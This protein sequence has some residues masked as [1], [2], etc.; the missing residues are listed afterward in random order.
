MDERWE[1]VE[2]LYHAARELDSHQQARFLD[3]ACRS[4]AQMRQQVDD[5]LRHDRQTTSFLNTPAA[6]QELLHKMK[7]LVESMAADDFH[8]TERF[9]VLRRLGAGG[10][11]VVYE[12]QDPEVRISTTR[13]GG[14]RVTPIGEAPS[15]YQTVQC[16]GD[17]GGTR[18]HTR[19]RSDDGTFSW[20]R[21]RPR[22]CDPRNTSL[23]VARRRLWDACFPGW[24][25]VQ[26]GSH[27]IRGADGANSFPRFGDRR[28]PP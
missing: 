27:A 23:R 6:D 12:V 21:R 2:S 10:M 3:E 18:R 4:D 16:A 14:L 5:L 11:G 9:T 26:R 20:K 8:G 17:A 28:T 22:A 15:R 25:L 24:R 1:K 19:L 7:S 13:G